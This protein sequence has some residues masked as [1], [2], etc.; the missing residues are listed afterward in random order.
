MEDLGISGELVSDKE[1]SQFALRK[2]DDALVKIN[3][4]R[5]EL[6]AI[7]NRLQTVTNTL[8]ITEEN[9]SAANSRIRD[10]DVA[11]ES[12]KLTKSNILAQAGTSVLAQANQ[13]PQFAL[14]LIG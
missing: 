7:Q 8:G 5:A 1:S 3:G 6:G 14:K 9:F 2:L 4:N 11:A 12:A 10:V 13:T